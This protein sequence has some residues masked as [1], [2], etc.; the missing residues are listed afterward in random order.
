MTKLALAALLVVACGKPDE[1]YKKQK[2][3]EEEKPAEPAVRTPPP[4]PKKELKPEEMGKCELHA[5]GAVKADQTS[6]GGRPATNISYWFTDEEKK[7]M[8][9]VDGFVVNC[10]GPDIKFS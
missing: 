4:P 9:G 8:M 2:P 7:N 1:D 3:P 10:H 5:T 6:M